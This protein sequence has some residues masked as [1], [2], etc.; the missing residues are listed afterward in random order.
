MQVSFLP[1]KYFL[2]MENTPNLK[3]L[4]KIF[5][6]N[7]EQIATSCSSISDLSFFCSKKIKQIKHGDSKAM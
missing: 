5:T 4:L 2:L 3:F 6:K 7:V 1:K